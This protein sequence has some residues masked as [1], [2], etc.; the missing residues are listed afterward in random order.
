VRNEGGR[1]A[2]ELARHRHTVCRRCKVVTLFRASPTD[3]AG[4]CWRAPPPD[5]GLT[6]LSLL[7]PSSHPR[8]PAA[9]RQTF[10]R[11]RP[12][13]ARRTYTRGA[14]THALSA[15]AAA[16]RGS[17]ASCF[18]ARAPTQREA[19]RGSLRAAPHAVVAYIEGTCCGCGCGCSVGP[20]HAL[21]ART[22]ARRAAAA[23]RPRAT[24]RR[25]CCSHLRS[26]TRP[27]QSSAV[28]R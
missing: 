3:R 13:R 19:V 27:R 22:A 12:R 20:L 4:V 8:R 14:S 21:A 28:T 26:T 2:R 25:P 11:T 18:C 16:A 10:L 9:R 23:L 6:Q 5:S 17:S 24:A 7:L 15:R 1:A